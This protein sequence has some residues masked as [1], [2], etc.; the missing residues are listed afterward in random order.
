MRDRTELSDELVERALAE[1]RELQ[2]RVIRQA[3]ARGVAEEI[4]ARDLVPRAR[5]GQPSATEVMRA[6]LRLIEEKARNNPGTYVGAHQAVREACIAL[7]VHGAETTAIFRRTRG[8]VD[9]AP[10]P[11]RAREGV[12]RRR[13]PPPTRLAPGERLSG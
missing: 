3:I 2:R 8:E 9:A 6:C 13:L 7:G 1:T 12:G 10:N 5:E 11:N 4:A